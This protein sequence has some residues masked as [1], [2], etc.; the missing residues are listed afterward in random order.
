[1][2]NFHSRNSKLV[3]NDFIR[4]VYD[5]QMFCFSNE[6]YLTPAVSDFGVKIFKEAISKLCV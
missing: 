2:C 5:N 3:I 4:E 1:M 6:M